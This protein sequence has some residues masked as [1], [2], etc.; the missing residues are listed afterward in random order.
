MFSQPSEILDFRLR[1]EVIIPYIRQN[2]KGV[3]QNSD[4][5]FFRKLFLYFYNFL[6]A[7]PIYFSKLA[8]YNRGHTIAEQKVMA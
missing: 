8:V 1:R 4:F 6:T 2:E 7:I 5:F 3:L